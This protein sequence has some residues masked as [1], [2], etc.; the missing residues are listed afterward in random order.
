MEKELC[1]VRQCLRGSQ[2]PPPSPRPPVQAGA[3]SVHHKSLQL[4]CPD[5]LE[6]NTFCLPRKDGRSHQTFSETRVSAWLPTKLDVFSLG[7]G[8]GGGGAG[9]SSA[10]FLNGAGHLPAGS[11]CW[12]TGTAFRHQWFKPR[13]TSGWGFY[14]D[15]YHCHG[16]DTGANEHRGCSSP[17]KV[18]S[19]QPARPKG[20][21][22]FPQKDFS[23]VI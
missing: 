10:T 19:V 11:L 18:S 13:P 1:C 12:D 14:K 20:N 9:K 6:A 16:Y 3:P 22:L 5:H 23:K 21:P 8:G 4:P 2:Q 17:S 7:D 15:L